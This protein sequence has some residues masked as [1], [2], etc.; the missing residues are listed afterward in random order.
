MKTRLFLSSHP[1]GFQ[2]AEH[3]LQPLFRFAVLSS[4]LRFSAFSFHSQSDLPVFIAEFEQFLSI[5]ALAL[6]KW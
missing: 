4:V 5:C 6:Q 3:G 2:H 1:E